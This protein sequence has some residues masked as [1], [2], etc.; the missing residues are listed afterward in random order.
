MKKVTIVAV[1]TALAASL[2]VGPAWAQLSRSAGRGGSLPAAPEAIL[3]DQTNNA[4]ANGS[5]D[6]DF[7]A[8][9][10]A[11]DSEGADDFVVNDATGWLV[12][13]VN[14]IGTTGTA[15][16]ATVDVTFYT[17]SAGGGDPDLPGSAVC[18]YTALT[19]VDT[20]GSFTIT[21]PTACTLCPGTYWVAIQT[22][23]SFGAF[24]QHFWSNRTT[25]TGSEGTWRNPG[26]GFATGCTS[27]TPQTICGVGGG[28]N[29]DYLFSI[30]GT[31][32]GCTADLAI[33]KTGVANGNQIVYTITVTNNGP[34]GAT[35]VVVT[36]TL[37][38]EV[39]YVSDTCGASNV[40][41]W[42]WNIG[43]LANGAS[44]SC[45]I[46][47][48]VN[49]PGAIVNAAT[50]DGNE[51]DPTPSNSTA[52]VTVQGGQVATVEVPTL[53]E[54]GLAIL[55]LLLTASGIY[56]LRRARV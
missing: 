8:A 4:S 37:P 17:N 36:D 33:T 6:Q 49:T 51:A 56:F 39:T 30:G 46:T 41:P 5:P 47:V 38:A 32:G 16:G 14:T 25:Q 3:Y 12:D 20:A 11:Y 26:N 9:F 21:L 18:T 10:N 42:T 22:N 24:G 28:T 15:G 40:P 52:T 43:S 55:L 53:G 23:Q 1:V 45:D 27:F 7:E 31:V 54:V 35:G 44:V 34:V 19:P 29:P 13:Q 48:D 2:L 50:V